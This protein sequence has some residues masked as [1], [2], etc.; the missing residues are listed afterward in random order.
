MQLKRYMGTAFTEPEGSPNITGFRLIDMFTRVLTNEKKDEVLQSFSKTDSVLRLVVA[1]TAFG[2]GIDCP[3]IRRIIH[4]GVPSNLEEYVQE[5]GRAGRD[6][7]SSV[8]TLYAGK[9]GKHAN[10][11]VRNYVSNT[12]ECRRRLL[13]QEFLLYTEFNIKVKGCKCCDVCQ[14]SCTCEACKS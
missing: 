8:A 13:F 5:T 7:K 11:K 3:N 14:Q 1:T 12:V 9:G 4:W 6:G 10:A 2:M